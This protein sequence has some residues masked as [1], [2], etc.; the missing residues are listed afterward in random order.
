MVSALLIST[1]QAAGIACF[2]A[3]EG[4]IAQFRI[5]QQELNVAALNCQTND[6]SAPGFREGYNAFIARFSGLL[7]DTAQPLKNH[8]SRVHG[9]LDVWT[10]KV[11]NDASVR[12]FTDHDFCQKAWVNLGHALTLSPTEVQ[13]FAQ[14]AIG[15]RAYLPICAEKKKKGR[16]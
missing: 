5:L 7:Q 3:E 13:S 9:S 6:P 4:K 11:A 16:L 2:N 14:G 12:V 1:G 10:T 15:V 8:F